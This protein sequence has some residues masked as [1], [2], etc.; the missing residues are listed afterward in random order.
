M[1]TIHDKTHN[2]DYTVEK[3]TTLLAL[4]RQCCP[5]ADPPVAAALYNNELAGLQTKIEENG[6][7][8]WYQL[9]TLEGNQCIIRTAILLLVRAV[10]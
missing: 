7:V 2:T 6:D 3:G 9:N 8:E 4:S 10:A 5:K 1:I